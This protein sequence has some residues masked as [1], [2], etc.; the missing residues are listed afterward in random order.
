MWR[1]ALALLGAVHA[2]VIQAIGFAERSARV[3][4]G[5]LASQEI[6]RSGQSTHFFHLLKIRPMLV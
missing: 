6:H 1:L 3:S 2:D 5:R 4:S